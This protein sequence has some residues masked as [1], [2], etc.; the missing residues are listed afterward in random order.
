MD[1]RGDPHEGPDR[2]VGLVLG[3]LPSQTHPHRRPGGG[4][5]DQTSTLRSC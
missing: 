5:S 4:V 1:F 2:G 3:E